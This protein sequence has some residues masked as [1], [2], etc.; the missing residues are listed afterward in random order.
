MKQ[1]SKRINWPAMALLASIAAMLGYQSW[2]MRNQEKIAPAVVVCVDLEKVFN[3]LTAKTNA[4]AH[5]RKLG[6]QQIAESNKKAEAIKQMEADLADLAAGSARYR[7]LQDQALLEAQKYRAY[8][9]FS[10]AK[11]DA[12]RSRT[13]KRIY[14][15]IKKAADEMATSNGYDLVLVNDSLAEIPPGT[16]EEMNRQI[17]ARRILFANP[18]I[19]LTDEL[20]AYMNAAAQKTP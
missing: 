10:R 4:D 20:I 6:E 15:D 11:I 18:R 14:G 16:E 5:L 3:G 7:E 8:V 12:E 9:E 2:A 17:S 19:D 1:H 13:I